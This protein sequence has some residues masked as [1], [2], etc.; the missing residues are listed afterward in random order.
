MRTSNGLSDDWLSTPPPASQLAH[1]V[2]LFCFVILFIGKTTEFQWLSGKTAL[3]TEI[4]PRCSG[5]LRRGVC[6]KMLFGLNAACVLTLIDVAVCRPPLLQTQI[7][8]TSGY[9]RLGGVRQQHKNTTTHNAALFFFQSFFFFFRF[10]QLPHFFSFPHR[11]AESSGTKYELTDGNGMTGV[12]RRASEGASEGGFIYSGK[13]RRGRALQRRSQPSI[14]LAD[15]KHVC[16][17]TL[18]R[19]GRCLCSFVII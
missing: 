4:T 18:G 8:H 12:E 10:L 14:P 7:T 17:K 1:F 2:L 16:S 9:Y 13:R 11:F 5:R 6:W 3:Q 19:A 15:R